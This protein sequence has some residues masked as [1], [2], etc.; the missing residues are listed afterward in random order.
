MNPHKKFIIWNKKI[1]VRV[2]YFKQLF[3]TV[4]FSDGVVVYIK[5]G[6]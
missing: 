1:F 2:Y 3:C 6:F 5:Q 4:F